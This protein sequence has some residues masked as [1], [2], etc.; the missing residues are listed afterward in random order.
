MKDLLTMPKVLPDEMRPHLAPPTT[1][2]WS[3]PKDSTHYHSEPTRN[4]TAEHMPD[5]LRNL[6]FRQGF[7]GEGLDHGTLTMSLPGRRL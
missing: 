4:L 6:S 5:G 3:G 2:V 7:D 1:V